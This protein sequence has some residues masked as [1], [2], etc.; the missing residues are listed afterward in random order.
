M[1]IE[2][3]INFQTGV[4]SMLQLRQI[5]QNAEQNTTLGAMLSEQQR[6]AE[7]Q[8]RREWLQ[9]LVF[10]ASEALK[11]L[12]GVP[13]EKRDT[14]WCEQLLEVC[15]TVKNQG[16]RPEVFADLS[17]KQVALALSQRLP[18]LREEAAQRLGEAFNAA[19]AR[20]AERER[21]AME[22]AE[23]HRQAALAAQQLEVLEVLEERVRSKNKTCLI[24]A[25]AGT[26]CFPVLVPV[27][28]IMIWSLRSELK[29]TAPQ[30]VR[31]TNLAFYWGLTYMGLFALLVVVAAFSKH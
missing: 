27:S 18:V 31:K 23:R 30:L 4:N 24:L 21:L 20:L 13:W 29:K 26:F 28:L 16:L 3:A 8:K 11:G 19:M 1:S 7:E 6:I 2:G 5:Q 14:N 12:E 15:S 25:A 17:Y 9:Q 10:A 22:E